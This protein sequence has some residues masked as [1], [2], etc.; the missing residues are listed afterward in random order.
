MDA[1]GGAIAGLAPVHFYLAD[2][3]RTREPGA[4]QGDYIV[5]EW[6]WVDLARLVEG[7]A[8]QLRFAFAS[9]DSGGFGINTPLYVAMDSA[10]ARAVRLDAPGRRRGVPAGRPAA[11]S[12]GETLN[13]VARFQEEKPGPYPFP[14]TPGPGT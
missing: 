2:F 8:S 13:G 3:R 10:R 1:S 5:K 12:A 4:V 14:S 6:T 11:P 7:G 9:S